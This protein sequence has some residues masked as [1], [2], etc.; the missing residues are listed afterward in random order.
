[1]IHG[2]AGGVG[3]FAVQLAKSRR[4]ARNP[5][6]STANQRT[7]RDL[8]STNPINYETQDPIETAFQLTDAKGVDAVFDTVGKNLIARSLRATDLLAESLHSAAWRR[9]IFTVRSVGT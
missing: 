4:R 2:G 9:F 8:A 5:M 6:A 3:S 7:L 1:L